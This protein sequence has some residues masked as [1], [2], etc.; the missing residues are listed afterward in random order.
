M[1]A[2][3]KEIK[4]TSTGKVYFSHKANQCS[5]CKEQLERS[6]LVYLHGD[7]ILCLS[8]ADIDHLVSCIPEH[9]NE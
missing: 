3:S 1:G 8:C 2:G 5:D 7:K 9:R 4:Q 6:E